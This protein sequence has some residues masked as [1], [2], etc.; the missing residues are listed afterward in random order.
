MANFQLAYML[1][2]HNEGGYVNDPKDKGGETV[3]GLARN[4]WPGWAGWHT[5]D[6]LKDILG[7]AKAIPAIN[8]N[9]QLKDSVKALFKANFWDTL[10][11]DS[12]LNQQIANQAFDSSIN[13]GVGPTAKMLQMQANVNVD[14][15]IG[16]KTLVAINYSDPETFYNGFIV[17]RKRRYDEIIANNPS[18]EKFRKSWYSRLTPYKK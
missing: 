12:I 15:H 13:T 2:A 14:L 18:Q 11:L 8:S 7:V 6:H 3:F 1:V 10:S 4:Y 5:I 9:Q 16:P 17:L